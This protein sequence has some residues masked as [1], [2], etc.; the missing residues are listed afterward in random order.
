MTNP[1][2]PLI[3]PSAPAPGRADAPAVRP[4]LSLDEISAALRDPTRR[5][6]ILAL[7]DEQPVTAKRKTARPA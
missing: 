1:R 2:R 5:S 4:A 7:I 3:T 6:E